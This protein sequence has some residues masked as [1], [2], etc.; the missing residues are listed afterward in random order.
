MFGEATIG[1]NGA[2]RVVLETLVGGKAFRTDP[3]EICVAVEADDGHV[4]CCCNR[5]ASEPSSA[6]RCRRDGPRLH[7][8][9]ERCSAFEDQLAARRQRVRIHSGTA[10]R[11]RS[12]MGRATSCVRRAH[13]SRSA[14]PIDAFLAQEDRTRGCRICRNAVARLR[15]SQHVLPILRDNCFRCHGDKDNGGLALNRAKRRSKGATPKHRPSSRQCRCD[16]E[17]CAASSEAIPRTDAAGWRRTQA[18][19][20]AALEEWIKSGA[21]WPAPPLTGTGRH[22]ASVC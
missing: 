12:P 20:I 3:G 15:V 22:S 5:G 21:D 4:S 14:H 19:Q 8:L 10:A 6:D 13:R 18:K 17:L 11:S 9:K 1:D 16:S 2:C 7:A